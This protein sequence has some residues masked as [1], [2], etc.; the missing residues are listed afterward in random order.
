MLNKESILF[1]R[2]ED[3]QL[4]PQD[5][6][7]EILDDKPTI[8][9]VPLT[10]GKLQEIYSKATSSSTEDKID[11]DNE[12]IRCGLV[13][14]KLSEEEITNLKPRF[15]TAISI[16]ILSLSLDI[17]QEEV[18]NKKEDMIAEQELELKKK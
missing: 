11:S 10:R 5:V 1:E 7:L 9:I 2:G 8:K 4:L 14:P 12:I 13:E 18:N 6:V 16:G 3:G 15:A 17:S